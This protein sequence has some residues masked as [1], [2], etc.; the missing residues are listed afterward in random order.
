LK[1]L[2]IIPRTPEPEDFYGNPTPPPFIKPE[3]ITRKRS[4]IDDGGML[5]RRNSK[6]HKIKA[7]MDLTDLPTDSE[8]ESDEATDLT[9]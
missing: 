6:R 9:L 7:T 3:E 8:D 4:S 2:C 1:K 5:Q